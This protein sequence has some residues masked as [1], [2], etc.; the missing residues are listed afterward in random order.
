MR[1]PLLILLTLFSLLSQWAW[2]EHAY[3]GHDSGEICEICLIG[4]AQTHGAM[5]AALQLPSAL[6]E[7]FEQPLLTQQILEQPSKRQN[8]RAPPFLSNTQS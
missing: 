3:H 6:P 2:I 7:R 8:I 5:P 4:Q 1:T